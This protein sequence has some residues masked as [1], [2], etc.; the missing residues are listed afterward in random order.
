MR[1]N[2]SA[3]AEWYEKAAKQ[4][5][6]NSQWQLGRILLSGAP[7]MVEGSVAV[8]QDKDA[9]IR[10]LLLVANQGH[11]GA[12]LDIARCYE[13]GNGVKQDYVEAYKWYKLASQRHP[14]SLSGKMSLDRLILKLTLEQIQEGE[15]RADG[16][17]P[18]R[19]QVE[20]PSLLDK[21]VLKGIS[22]DVGHRMA[23][24]NNKTV[25]VGETAEIKV[26]EKPVKV[27]CVKISEKSVLVRVEGLEGEK[28]LHLK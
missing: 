15:R 28:E 25:E 8:P 3:A 18:G 22:G 20:L 10:W 26:G 2:Y 19:T 14:Y 11:G 23:V 12:Q 27:H 17:S 1:M 21:I 6:V 7:K 4:G 13:N 16:F 5:I 9:A 24:I